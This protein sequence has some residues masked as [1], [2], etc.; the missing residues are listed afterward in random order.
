[1]AKPLAATGQA[2]IIAWAGD[3][4][5]YQITAVFTTPAM[6][7]QQ[8]GPAA[9]LRRGLSAWRRGLPRGVPAA[10]TPTASRS[11]MPRP[12]RRSP[13]LKKYVFTGDPKARQ[14]ILDGVGYYDAGGALDVKDVVAQ[15]A[16][17]RGAGAGEGRGRPGV[18]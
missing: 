9:A 8:A 14:K 1:M 11:S 12:T 6:I 2:H 15:V 10:R 3:I 5:P 7:A 16:W 13:L 18:A 4:V 17:F